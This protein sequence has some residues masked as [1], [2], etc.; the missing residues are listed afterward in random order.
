MTQPQLNAIGIAERDRGQVVFTGAALAMLTKLDQALV[1]L[2]SKWD[3][4]EHVFPPVLSAEPLRRLDYFQSF[5]HLANFPVSLEGSDGN[6]RQFSDTAAT[7]DDSIHLTK[8]APVDQVLT[9]AACY[10]VYVQ[11]QDSEL[12]GPAFFTTRCTCFRRENT[13]TAMRRQWAFQMRE[14]V[15]IGT[16]SEVDTF[17]T[18]AAGAVSKFVEEIG[19]EVDWQ[20]A[21]DPFF[22]PKKNAKYIMQ[23]AEPSKKELVFGGDL[24]LGSVNFH[25]EH[26][27]QAFN[28]RRGREVASSGCIA[29]GLERWMAAILETHGLE[30]SAWPDLDR[31]FGDE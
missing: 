30:P 13:Y 2:A 28:I 1:R 27:G 29:F 25:R 11:A 21:T 9:P 10:H 22:Q 18:L 17:L 8:L 31:Y 6:L 5:P 24:A 16:A 12:N 19:L 14:I 23:I 15:V 3:A 4:N 7:Q 26:F 20:T